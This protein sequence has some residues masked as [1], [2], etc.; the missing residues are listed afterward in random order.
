MASLRDGALP[1]KAQ[2]D[3]VRLGQFHVYQHHGRHIPD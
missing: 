3:N 2:L 1:F